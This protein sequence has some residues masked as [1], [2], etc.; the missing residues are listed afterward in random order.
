[1]GCETGEVEFLGGLGFGA[2]APALELGAGTG[3]LTHGL[4]RAGCSP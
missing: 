2:D 4:V 3:S 1:M